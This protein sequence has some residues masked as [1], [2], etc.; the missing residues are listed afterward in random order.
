MLSSLTIAAIVVPF[1]F[2]VAMRLYLTFELSI[3]DKTKGCMCYV[4]ILNPQVKHT[5]E[6]ERCQEGALPEDLS[7][8]PGSRALE[9]KRKQRVI[10]RDGER[11]APLRAHRTEMASQLQPAH[12]LLLCPALHGSARLPSPH[13]GRVVMRCW[14][15]HQYLAPLPLLPAGRCPASRIG[16]PRTAGSVQAR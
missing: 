14:R 3:Q 1:R 9:R 11:R 16:L 8:L 6:R 15:D 4:T 13:E 7:A 2:S 10:S 12:A 5:R